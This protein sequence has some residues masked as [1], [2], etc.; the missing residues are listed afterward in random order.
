[1][2]WHAYGRQRT[3][4]D[5]VTVLSSYSRAGEGIWLSDKDITDSSMPSL[6]ADRGILIDLSDSMLYGSV[7][8][9]LGGDD[10]AAENWPIITDVFD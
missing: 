3:I 6:T 8:G 10:S 2:A 1:M 7:Y 9:Y 4:G 5:G